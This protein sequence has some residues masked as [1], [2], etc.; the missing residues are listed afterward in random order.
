MKRWE[1]E[2][3]ID[4]LEVLNELGE[5]RPEII[6]QRKVWIDF[7]KQRIEEENYEI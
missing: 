3:K 2:D 1:I 7:Y 4:C 6:E 5:D